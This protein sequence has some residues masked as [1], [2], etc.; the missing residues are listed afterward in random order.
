MERIAKLIEDPKTREEA[1]KDIL[2]M[3]DENEKK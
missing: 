1:I 3:I 2:K